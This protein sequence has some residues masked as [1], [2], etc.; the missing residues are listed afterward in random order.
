VCILEKFHWPIFCFLVLIGQYLSRNWLQTHE[1]NNPR[2]LHKYIYKNCNLYFTLLFKCTF[3]MHMTHS[4]D[5]IDKWHIFCKYG[6]N[7]RWKL[8]LSGIF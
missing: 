3:M 2:I 8:L 4:Q 1:G 6:D 5:V 7:V